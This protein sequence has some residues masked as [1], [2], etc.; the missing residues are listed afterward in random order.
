[1]RLPRLTYANVAATVALIVAVAGGTALAVGGNASS[2]NG[3]RTA[4][5]TYTTN[6][7]G[8]SNETYTTIADIGGLKLRAA[9]A[10]PPGWSV[11]HLFI[12]VKSATDNTELMLNDQ[13]VGAAGED[14]DQADGAVEVV[15]DQNGQWTLTYSRPSGANVV[16]TFYTGVHQTP[17]TGH[18]DCSV[19]G[20]AFY[21]PTP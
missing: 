12:N 9:C 3:V 2:V 17:A 6:T 5:I 14:F 20:V 4:R 19:T 10:G 11:N 16:A 7:S 1:V 13:Y 15:E 21:S 8:A 18:K